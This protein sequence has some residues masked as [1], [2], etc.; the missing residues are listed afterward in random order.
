MAPELPIMRQPTSFLW[1]D[2]ETWGINPRRDGIAQFAAV[3]TDADL[4]IISEPV[5]WKCRPLP[6]T[7][8]DPASCLITGLSP[9]QCDSEGMTEWEFAENIHRLMSEPGTCSTGYNT[10]R[11]DDEFSR[12]L[13]YRNLLDPYSREWR[14]GNSRWDLLDVVRLTHALRPEGLSW[15][16][17]EDGKPSFKLEHLSA[18]NGIEHQN[19]HDAVSDVLATIEL[20]RLIRRHQPKLFD[21]ALSLRFKHEVRRLLAI[22][23]RTPY[24]HV[25]GMIPAERGCLTVEL[26]LIEHPERSNEIIALDLIEDPSWLLDHNADDVRKWLYT[27][28]NEL[29]EGIRRPPLRTLHINRSPMIAPYKML[30]DTVAERFQLDREAMERHRGIVDHWHDLVTLARDVFRSE[31]RTPSPDP[32]HALYEGFIQDHD[33]G[34]LN[35]IRRSSDHPE[36][37]S[38]IADALHDDR[39]KALV[40]NLRG[41]HFPGSLSTQE[42]AVWCDQVRNRL[43]EADWGSSLTLAEATNRTEALMAEN[44]ESDVLKQVREWCARQRRQ[45]LDA[46][47]RPGQPSPD[48]KQEQPDETDSDSSNPPPQLDLF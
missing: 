15:P 3:R 10:L 24:L 17:H 19:A 35:Q 8:I 21:Y 37:W 2:Y 46:P 14:N 13:F 1:Y 47:E 7:V 38:G 11:F 22:E 12:H 29:P 27:P 42:Q 30:D 41:R 34:V 18:A 44:P 26:P 5:D 33:R 9:Q 6:D 23:E 4:N 20:A 40:F 28:A 31:D 16:T 43:N 25:S 32:E 39:Q 45:W 48:V 36:K